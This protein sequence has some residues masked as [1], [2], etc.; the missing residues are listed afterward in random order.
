MATH[1]GGSDDSNKA[2]C[3]EIV[4]SCEICGQDGLSD[5]QMREHMDCVHIRGAVQCPFCDL[6]TSDVT[7]SEMTLHV[8]TA[9]L[10]YLTPEREDVCFLE[11]DGL[12]SDFDSIWQLEKSAK[13]GLTN[14]VDDSPTRVKN[15]NCIHAARTALAEADSPM[16][17]CTEMSDGSNCFSCQPTL[18]NKEVVA[19][20]AAAAATSNPAS[21]SSSSSSPSHSKSSSSST[22][23]SSGAIQKRP[24]IITNNGNSTSSPSKSSLTLNIKP[25]SAVLQPPEK[26]E[27]KLAPL[28]SLNAS[29]T[30]LADLFQCPMC[31]HKDTDPVKLQE[32]VNRS[33]FDPASPIVVSNQNLSV[34]PNAAKDDNVTPSS[35]PC[36]LCSSHYSNSLQLERHVNRDH[37]DILSPHVTKRRPTLNEMIPT[38]PTPSSASSSSSMASSAKPPKASSSPDWNGNQECPVCTMSGFLNQNQLA[39]HIDAHFSDD[40]PHSQ[41]HRQQQQQQQ[42][43]KPAQLTRLGHGN[44]DGNS[45]ASTSSSSS[46]AS[47]S[48]LSSTKHNDYLLAQELERRERER[49]RHEEQKEFDQLRAQ[50][51]MDNDGNFHQQ[52]ISNMQKAVYTGEMS[53]VDYYERQT[54]L[55][56][57]ERSGMDDGRSVSRNL[58]PR[59][60]ALS[61][62]TCQAFYCSSV[63]HHSSSFGDKGWGCGYRNLQM[64]LSSLA[65]FTPTAECLSLN[66]GTG[67]ASISRLQGLIEAAWAKGF[68]VQGSDQLGGRLSNTRKWIGATEIVAFLTANRIKAELL[69][70]HMPTGRDGTHP[71]LFQWVLEY[72][73][74]RAKAKA[75]TP[76]LYLQH[77]GHSRTIVGIEVLG[78]NANNANLR[79]IVFDPSH[80][81]SHMGTLVKGQDPAQVMRM[82]RKAPQ[83]IKCKQYQIVA[84]TGIYSSEKEAGQHK[85]IRSKRIP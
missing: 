30:S 34:A 48:S 9:H 46:S 12:D 4:Y 55:R 42:Q 10:E 75:F 40:K 32:H 45:I 67:I 38:S 27:E 28:A 36:P 77:Q 60:K 54:E 8:N 29:N 14:G 17:T 82:L 84:V 83:A 80:S 61:Q 73:R 70:F 59:L 6:S 62:V 19:A 49:R 35:L 22:P 71:K 39:E 23:P 78:N 76:P 41:Q 43:A 15:L 16:S 53:V 18:L 33:H 5:E 25:W 85:V 3:P 2:E 44:S 20:A 79:L 72:F 69:D 56:Q 13:E 11:D 65:L 68:D 31:D 50:F 81:R 63:D 51:G 24:K 1:A 64:L 66:K 21:C 52:S 74:E 7:P 57:A 26:A 47:S 37:S 58:I